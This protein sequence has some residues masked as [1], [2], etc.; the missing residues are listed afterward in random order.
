MTD[1]QPQSTSN[2]F[3]KVSQECFE[4]WQAGRHFYQK[5]TCAS[6]GNRQSM[7]KPNTIFASGIC[8]VC[9]YETNLR[10]YGCGYFLEI[11]RKT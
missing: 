3:E 9:G 5:F 4:H 7:D 8:D 2:A 6:C 11:S 10:V 1:L